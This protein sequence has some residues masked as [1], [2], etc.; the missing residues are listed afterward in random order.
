MAGSLTFCGIQHKWVETREFVDHVKDSVCAHD[1]LQVIG[2]YNR[3][4]DGITGQELGVPREQFVCNDDIGIK[5]LQA[6]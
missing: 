3:R 1:A 2:F 4:V 5:K 6:L